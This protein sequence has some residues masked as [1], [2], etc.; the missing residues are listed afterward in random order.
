MQHEQTWDLDL[1]SAIAL[2]VMETK[3]VKNGKGIGNQEYAPHFGIQ[4][5]SFKMGKCKTQT[6]ATT[7]KH[8]N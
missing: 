2:A 6:S 5:F 7:K 8:W 4:P 3:L 1:C